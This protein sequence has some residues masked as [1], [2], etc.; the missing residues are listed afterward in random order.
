M[1]VRCWGAMRWPLRLLAGS[2]GTSKL[3]L[4]TGGCKERQEGQQDDPAAPWRERIPALPGQRNSGKA[5]LRS[6]C[7]AL[8]GPRAAVHGSLPLTC[9]HASTDVTLPGAD[10]VAQDGAAPVGALRSTRG[11]QEQLPGSGEQKEA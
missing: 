10:A 11:A 7:Q 3:R 1:V 4:G 2:A 6:R 9:A 5:A 8:L